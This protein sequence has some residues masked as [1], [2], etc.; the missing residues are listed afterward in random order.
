MKGWEEDLLFMI[1]G[2]EEADRIVR[3]FF[4][5]NQYTMTNFEGCC[6]QKWFILWVTLR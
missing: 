6:L 2:L 4:R 3:F 5:V 1:S